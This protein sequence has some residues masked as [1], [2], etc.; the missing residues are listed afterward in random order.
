MS[1]D[2]IGVL[3]DVGWRVSIDKLVLLSINGE[4]LSLWIK[5]SKRAGSDENSSGVSLLL[6][7]LL[8]MHLKRKEKVYVRKWFKKV[9]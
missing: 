4:R 8:G 7:V 6:L 5:R 9:T 1:N 2:E 3:V